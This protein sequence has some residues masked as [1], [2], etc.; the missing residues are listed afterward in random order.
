[1]PKCKPLTCLVEIK[2]LV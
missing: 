1:M 2:L